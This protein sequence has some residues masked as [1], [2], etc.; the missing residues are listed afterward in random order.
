VAVGAQRLLAVHT[1]P[2]AVPHPAPEQQP[3]RT[4]HIRS[5]PSFHHRREK[6]CQVWQIV[7]TP[8]HPLTRARA[9]RRRP[10]APA[11]G[12]CRRRANAAGPLPSRAAAHHSSAANAR[13][14][15]RA[16][17]APPQP[18]RPPSFSTSR[19]VRRRLRRH[20]A[21]RL[22]RPPPPP[23]AAPSSMPKPAARLRPHSLAASPSSPSG[24][25]SPPSLSS[26]DRRSGPDSSPRGAHPSS[27]PPSPGLA[28]PP[29]PSRRRS[30]TTLRSRPAP[31][32]RCRRPGSS[33]RR[34][35]PAHQSLSVFSTHP[36]ILDA[37]TLQA[38]AQ[39]TQL[40][41]ALPR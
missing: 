1:A 27:S 4:L 7:I 12:R 18:L 22:A 6:N 11:P 37:A 36:A 20:Q 21:C 15:A 9:R 13:A 16:P 26:P 40:A 5:P 30:D 29:R 14:R 2:R 24:P 17:P 41:A 19:P 25:L 31:C 3:K 8:M 35:C 10:R 32:H 39:A 38:A 33:A 34:R 23:Y 28:P